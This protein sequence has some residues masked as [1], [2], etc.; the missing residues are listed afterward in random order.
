MQDIGMAAGIVLDNVEWE[1]VDYVIMSDDGNGEGLNIP[2]MMISKQDSDLMMNF[3]RSATIEEASS[4]T[5]GITFQLDAP[6][7][8][9]EYNLWYTSSDDRSLDFLYNLAEYDLKLGKHSHFTPKFVYWECYWCEEQLVKD[10][11]Y[12]NGKYCAIDTTNDR[13]KGTEIIEEDLR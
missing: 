12:G 5:L 1:D 6:D 4:V 9:V 11:C 8:T 10:N 3:L 7:N 2:S 13:I